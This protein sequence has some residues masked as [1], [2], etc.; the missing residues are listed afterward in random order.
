MS[1][2]NARVYASKITDPGAA[3][4]VTFILEVHS[5]DEME[6]HTF[7]LSSAAVAEI[8]KGWGLKNA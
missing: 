2:S 5:F 3:D 8:A 7:R 4:G 6:H 1:Q